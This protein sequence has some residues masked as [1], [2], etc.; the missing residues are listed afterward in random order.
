MAFDDVRK[1]AVANRRAVAGGST[2]PRPPPE[3]RAAPVTAAYIAESDFAA[4][5][6]REH[7]EQMEHERRAREGMQRLREMGLPTL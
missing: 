1:A 5:V 4:L 6:E 2:E 7:R 3:A